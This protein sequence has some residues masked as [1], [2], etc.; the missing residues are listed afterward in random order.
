MR[1]FLARIRIT[2]SPIQNRTWSSANGSVL[3]REPPSRTPMLGFKA[4]RQLDFRRYG[5]TIPANCPRSSQKCWQ[6]R[7]KPGVRQKFERDIPAKDKVIGLVD[8][9]H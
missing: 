3:R 2:T 9:A 1:L 8:D 4:R 6:N 5:S 7:R